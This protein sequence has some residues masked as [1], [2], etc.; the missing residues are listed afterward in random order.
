MSQIKI[1]DSVK[2]IKSVG[3]KRAEL[4]EKI[5]IRSI[6]DLLFFLPTR[7]LDR[8]TTLTADK[9]IDHLINGYEGEVTIIG[10]VVDS[11][12]IRYGKKQIFK[13][14]MRDSTGF[15]EC[16]WFQGIKFFKGRFQENE[17]YAIAAKPVLTKY[18]NL[19]FSHPDFDKLDSEE[20]SDFNNTGKIIPFYKLPKEVKGKNLGDYSL[21]KIISNA[22]ENFGNQLKETLPEEIIK[23]NDLGGI[24]ETIQSIHFPNSLEQLGDAKKR[25]KFEELF[26]LEALLALRKFNIK[27]NIPGYSFKVKSRLVHN[28]LEK[29]P[30]ELTQAQLNVLHDIRLDM[31]SNSPMNRMLQGDV[32]S[33]KTIVAL[34]SMLITADN[35]YQSV[36]M[37]PTEILANQHYKTISSLLAGLN[38]NVYLLLG[39]QKKSERKEI[40]EKINSDEKSIIIG[41]H[42]LFEDEVIFRKLGL[43]VIDE[44]HRFGVA[45]RSRLIDKSHSPDILIMTATPIPRTLTMT[46]YGDLDLSIIKERP[47]NRLPIKTYLR[48]EK[49][50][51]DIYKFICDKNKEGY[52]AYIVYPLVEDS[53]KLDLKSAE[54]H[55]AELKETYFS[56]ISLGIV[57]G[58]M[59]WKEKEEVMKGF[60][61]KKFDVL[62]S[63]TV[64]EVGID[65]PDANIMVINDA[66]RFGLS[67]L[68]QLR[69][70]VG[71]S[72]KQAYCILVAED[73]FV[74]SS[75]KLNFN[76]EYLS[77]AQIE[78]FKAAIR[79]SSMVKCNS[80]FDLS[81]ID[82]KLRGPGNIFGTEQSGLPNLQFSD[83]REDTEILLNAKNSAFSIIENDPTLINPAYNC[84][85]RKLKEVYS[86]NLKFSQIA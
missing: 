3:P 40:L 29:L 39:G 55:F 47:G 2:Y 71:R 65:I 41:T 16:V 1:T 5:G 37:A 23:S 4:F 44:Q 10:R 31:E 67:Q 75:N 73:K 61:D 79:L 77:N 17:E 28:F 30:F 27:G 60:S 50:L 83:L 15:F 48:G 36:I 74:V 78:K 84:I 80:G 70:R 46:V 13:V 43:V 59:S 19:Q 64:I 7:H 66:S 42:A 33:G 49:K 86:E 82:L 9:V 6:K 26:Y 68:H 69:G 57:H 51:P 58:K 53:D 63:T 25:F 24:N 20:F 56:D 81:E 76:F 14:Q 21:R 35:G 45:Q 34:I 54:T 52:Q 11:E 18:G 32:G 85:K 62:I 22:V 38:I 12:I 8:S 72:D